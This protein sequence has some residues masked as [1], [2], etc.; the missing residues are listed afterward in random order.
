MIIIDESNLRT[1]SD[2]AKQSSRKR[3]TYNYHKSF[4]EN[5]N[6]M[7]NAI[8]PLSYVQPHK[9][10]DPDKVEVFL[11]LKGRLLV[12]IFDDKGNNEST[13]LDNKEGKYGIEIPPKVWHTII[14]LEQN[15]VIFE[16]K[17]GPYNPETDKNFAKWAP[18]E[19]DA[20]A[21]D[22]I[23]RILDRLQIK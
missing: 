7:L 2:E 3:K 19:S 23:K 21:A 6:R 4:D 5:I 16:V 20:D 10:E 11:V 22:Y 8:E 17:D 18:K 14:S 12:V 15:T 9:H 13:I 1:L